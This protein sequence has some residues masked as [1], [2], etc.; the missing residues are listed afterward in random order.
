MVG[1]RG[2][3][4]ITF[5]GSEKEEENYVLLLEGDCNNFWCLAMKQP[6][7]EILTVFHLLLLQGQAQACCV[8]M[9]RT[10]PEGRGA[11]FPELL[12]CWMPALSVSCV[13]LVSRRDVTLSIRAQEQRKLCTDV[14]GLTL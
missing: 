13:L 7:G 12:D 10:A 9:A 4:V 11:D 6:Q 14:L 1:H 3:V 5:H 2:C 8:W